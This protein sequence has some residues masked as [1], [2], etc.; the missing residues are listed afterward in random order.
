[1]YKIIDSVEELYQEIEIDKNWTGAE[2][3]L[4]NR[5]PLRFVRAS[6]ILMHSYKNVVIIA[7]LCK[8]WINGWMRAMMMS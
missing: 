6:M 5:Y 2:C 7:F 1:M 3:S 8:V 4:R